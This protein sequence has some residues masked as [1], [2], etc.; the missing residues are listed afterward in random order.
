M[1][2]VGV[3]SPGSL[4]QSTTTTRRYGKAISMLV[5]TPKMTSQVC[6]SS[7]AAPKT[8]N[9]LVKPLVSGMPATASRMNV[10]TSVRGEGDLDAAVGA[11]E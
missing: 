8:A 11:A 2:T 6:P 5:I 9:L 1:D 7:T 3:D 4:S 10:K